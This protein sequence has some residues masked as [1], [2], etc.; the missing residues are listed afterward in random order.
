MNPSY[1]L[2]TPPFVARPPPLVREKTY[3]KTMPSIQV[4]GLARRFDAIFDVEPI[5]IPPLINPDDI[6]PTEENSVS[7]CTP[8]IPRVNSNTVSSL[9]M[10]ALQKNTNNIDRK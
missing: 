8:I 3:S 1:Q 10:P 5:G 4:D 9:D 7:Q 6:P 2:H